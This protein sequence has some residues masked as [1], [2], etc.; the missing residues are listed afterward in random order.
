[1]IIGADDSE[2]RL[3]GYDPLLQRLADAHSLIVRCERH[4]DVI[5]RM[6]A[7]E[8]ITRRQAVHDREQAMRDDE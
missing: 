2:R 5:A 8:K 7:R 3:I 4:A 6:M 1:M